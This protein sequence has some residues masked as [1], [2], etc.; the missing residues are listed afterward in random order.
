MKKLIKNVVI[1]DMTSTTPEAVEGLTIQ[2]AVNVFVTTSTRPLLGKVNFGNI[3]NITEI[4][5]G[6]TFSFM[7]GNSIFDGNI[8]AS[9]G[10]KKVYTYI[11]GSGFVNNNITADTFACLFSAG[12]KVNGNITLPNT[13]AAML[14]LLNVNINGNTTVYP[15]DT[16]L[17][18]QNITINDGFI[19]GLDESSKITVFGTVYVSH[20]T[21]TELFNKYISELT[22]FGNAIIYQKH[23]DIFYKAA[24]KY[25]EVSVIPD[26]YEY[27]DTPL[28]VGAANIYTIKG[29]SLYTRNDVHFKDEIDKN[30]INNIDF[31]LITEG[32][33]IVPETIAESIF[34]RVKT[35]SFNTYKG[36]LVIVGDEMPLRKP[37]S[38]QSY[39]IK[40]DAALTVPGDISSDDIQE[41]I[42]NIFLYGT[43]YLRDFQMEAIMEKIVI[44][45]GG[46]EIIDDTPPQ[47]ETDT[48]NN[49]TEEY[50][51][52]IGNAVNYI[53]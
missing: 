9:L 2:N 41:Y 49:E 21:N 6:A 8:N 25:S 51:I 39:I 12:G 47:E 19:N 4:A 43:I 13:L 29:K 40:N 32:A 22:I 3:V 53:L 31:R 38:M 23:R 10:E 15:A 42:G 16:L 35:N 46:I 24:H 44:N 14:P 45:E 1:L 48:Q 27:F 26:D 36:K 50:D 52:I 37:K 33:V 18:G 5:D 30:L 7:N 34:D 28:L 11:N 17:Y 20:D